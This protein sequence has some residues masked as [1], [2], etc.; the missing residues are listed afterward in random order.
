M[1]KIYAI[2]FFTTLSTLVYPLYLSNTLSP[3]LLVYLV[4]IMVQVLR[5]LGT[6]PIFLKFI[7]Y[8]TPFSVCPLG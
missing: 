7:Y 6:S 2:W 4:N 3:A 8:A 5:G 1:V